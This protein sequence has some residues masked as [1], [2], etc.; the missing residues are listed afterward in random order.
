MI[1]TRKRVIGASAVD[2]VRLVREKIAR[3]HAGDMRE[4]VKES[5]RMAKD[6][7]KK[8]GLKLVSSPVQRPHGPGG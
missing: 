1:K 7:R 2:E 8:L 5:R 4:H 3:Q 6:L